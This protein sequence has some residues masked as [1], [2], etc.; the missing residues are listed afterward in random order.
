MI[1]FL[2]LWIDVSIVMLGGGHKLRQIPNL[3]PCS[4]IV[5]KV[6]KDCMVVTL[7]AVV[8]VAIR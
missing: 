3:R 4:A 8:K 5:Q 1:N 2:K 6:Q 7:P